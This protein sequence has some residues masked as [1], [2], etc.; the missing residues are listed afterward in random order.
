MPDVVISPARFG[1]ADEDYGPCGC[2]S[3]RASVPVAIP[4]AWIEDC[5]ER[6]ALHRLLER[7]QF[8]FALGYDYRRV[9]GAVDDGTYF[10]NFSACPVCCQRAADLGIAVAVEDV[11]FSSNT[12]TETLLD[13][14]ADDLE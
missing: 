2:G 3:A 10:L 9:F 8:S 7:E 1:G 14:A 5:P 11:G 6:E 12:L 13:A 4:H